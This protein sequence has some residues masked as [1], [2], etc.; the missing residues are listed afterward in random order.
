MREKLAVRER[1]KLDP[2]NIQKALQKQII[3]DENL[4]KKQEIRLANK[5][6]TKESK[7]T[8]NQIILNNV[9]VTC[10]G[11]V[12][13]DEDPRSPAKTASIVLTPQTCEEVILIETSKI[14]YKDES[15]GYRKIP[16]EPNVN[17]LTKQEKRFLNRNFKDE[18]G[19]VRLPNLPKTSENH[20]L[21]HIVASI[22]R[23][24]CDNR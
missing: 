1:K 12:D 9:G 6:K 22:E 4:R 15:I 16:V 11:E 23:K 17:K 13:K 2:V 10:T 20:I 5:L 21:G 19:K 18:E 14:K 24:I 3:R 7:K 8:Q